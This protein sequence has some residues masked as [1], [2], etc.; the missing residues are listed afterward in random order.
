MPVIA[1]VS[2]LY[3]TDREKIES[4]LPDGWSLRDCQQDR[5]RLVEK[6]EEVEIVYGLVARKYLKSLPNLK[7]VQTT[8]SGVERLLY[9]E[10]VEN[11][12]VVTN[13]RGQCS[14]DIAEH[15]LASMLWL[16]RD[17]RSFEASYQQ[18]RWKTDHSR[19]RLLRGSSAL[20]VGTGAIG[21]TVAE[22][23]ASI[24][25]KVS[26]LNTSGEH[27]EP[28][29]AV[30]SFD[31]VKGHLGEFDHVVNCLPNTPATTRII[32]DTFLS[33]LREGVSL[34][35]IGRGATMDEEAVLH[36]LNSGKIGGM[37]LDVLADEPN[38]EES[39]PFF[40]HERVLLTGHTSCQ[41]ADQPPIA[42]E[43]FAKNLK[44]W[45]TSGPADLVMRVDKKAGY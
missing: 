6:G 4:I 44:A 1:V 10:M 23:L 5:G 33:A 22:A 43:V 12:V 7:W 2:T 16:T 25:I 40:G 34:Y 3:P 9:P 31:S 37:V 18:R 11:D 21:A 8:G 45:F 42:A 36:H 27:K 15:V 24:G 38:I 19:I 32:D 30:Y 28:F 20:I 26:G 17:L 29:D 41:P 14:D 35:N 39:H 13:L